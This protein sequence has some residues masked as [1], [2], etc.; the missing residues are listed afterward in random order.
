MR[1]LR[2]MT[3]AACGVV[4]A[5]CGVLNPVNAQRVVRVE[6]T[7]S[8]GRAEPS[9]CTVS[10]SGDPTGQSSWLTIRQSGE[11]NFTDGLTEMSD[12]S[13][14]GDNNQLLHTTQATPEQFA[15]L[16]EAVTSAEWQQLDEE[17]G[18]ATPDQVPQHV[19][20][21]GKGID[22]HAGAEQPAVLS[23]VMQQ[24]GALQQQAQDQ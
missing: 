16:N 15:A 18:A 4:V 10:T 1:A 9:L 23:D 13:F 21:G 17:Y 3:L 20:C 12:G 6:T 2:W 24:L 11:V 19:V 14:T 5:G 7:Q 8:S 22:V